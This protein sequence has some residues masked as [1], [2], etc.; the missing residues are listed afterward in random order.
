MSVRRATRLL[1][2]GVF[3]ATTALTQ[4]PP[5]DAQEITPAALPQTPYV[6]LTA[7]DKFHG[8]AVQIYAPFTFAAAGLSAGFG[9]MIGTP[10]EYG[11]GMEGYGKR[12]GTSLVGTESSRFFNHFLFPVLFRQDP[13]YFPARPG[14]RFGTRIAYAASRV[15]IGRHDSGRSRLNFSEVCG[16]LS[17]ASLS[18][19]Y[20]APSERSFRDTMRRF[21]TSLLTHGL[22]NLAREFWPDAKRL[23]AGRRRR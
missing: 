21:G 3:C 17:A 11:G 1:A 22:S 20:Y 8:F 4:V 19:A 16:N 10:R 23:L 5:A 2:A 14:A 15:V 13:R 6:P 7:R 9:Q 12:F 18:N